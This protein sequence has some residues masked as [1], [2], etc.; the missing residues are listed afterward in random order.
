MGQDSEDLSQH[1]RQ[2]HMVHIPSFLVPSQ[3]GLSLRTSESPVA[4][5]HFRARARQLGCSCRWPSGGKAIDPPPK[6]WASSARLKAKFD[7]CLAGF[8][9]L[10]VSR[11]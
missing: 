4:A 2:V 7:D 8:S 10:L 3:S 11:G 9:L 6:L 1:M 5:A